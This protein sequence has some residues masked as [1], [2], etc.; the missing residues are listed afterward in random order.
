MVHSVY[1]VSRIRKYSSMGSFTLSEVEISIQ[2]FIC[3]QRHMFK[4]HLTLCRQQEK[5]IEL[6]I[7]HSLS[8]R[9]FRSDPKTVRPRVAHAFV[10]NF[11]FP[12]ARKI[13]F[14][15]T[16]VQHKRYHFKTKQAD[17]YDISDSEFDLLFPPQQ[18]I[19]HRVSR[20]F[21]SQR[22]IDFGRPTCTRC[23]PQR[24]RRLMWI[25]PPNNYRRNTS[26]P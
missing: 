11:N 26:M 5:Y 21:L 15:A 19:V 8:I 16:E 1:K 12:I 10:F 14:H 17:D 22:R 4:E 7:C 20:R 23:L 24:L 25:N 3:S 6:G 2:R 9:R 13:H 18:D